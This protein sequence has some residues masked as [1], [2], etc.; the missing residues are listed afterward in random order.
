MLTKKTKKYKS[1]RIANIF[2]EAG[3][4]QRSKF[5]QNSIDAA[6]SA[7][8]KNNLGSTL[9]AIGSGAMGIV[10]ASLANAEIDTTT[11]DNAIDAVNSFQPN[12]GSLSALSSSYNNLNFADTSYD[13]KDYMVSTKQGL[14]N[15]GKAAMSGAVAGAQVGGPW[16]AI[17]RGAV[18]LLGSGAGW[19]AGKSKAKNEAIRLETEALMAN[20]GAENKAVTS[21][22][23]LLGDLANAERRNIVARGGKIFT[24]RDNLFDTGGLMHQHG[25]IFSNG[26]ITVDN[27]GTHEE[28]P[29][30]GVQIGV[31]N[32]GVPNLV[33]E[34]E[35]IWN[36]YV[37]SNRLEPSEEFKKK[38]K[39]KGNTFAEV[40]K[41][42]QKES[43]ERPNDPIS[44]RGLEYLMT[45]LMEEQEIVR[46]ISNKETSENMFDKGGKKSNKSKSDTLDTTSMIDSIYEHDYYVNQLG[47]RSVEE[48]KRLER[49]AGFENALGNIAGAVFPPPTLSDLFSMFRENKK[50][51]TGRKK[52]NKLAWG[53]YPFEDEDN[54]NTGYSRMSPD[55]VDAMNREAS[56]IEGRQTGMAPEVVDA[57][58]EQNRTGIYNGT[59]TNKPKVT[60]PASTSSTSFGNNWMRYTPV[61]GSALGALSDIAGITNKPDYTNVNFI[62]D[63]TDRIAPINYRPINARLSYTPFDTQFYAGKLGNQVAATKRAI[64]NTAPTASAAMSGLLT[65]DY[66]GQ[67]KLGELYRSAEEYNQAQKEKVL[68]FNR[69]TEALNSEGFLKADTINK[70]ADKLKLQSAIYQANLRNQIDATASAAKS[71]NLTNFFDNMGAVGKENY[72]MNMIEKNPALLYNW[73]GEYKNSS[74]CGGMLTKRKRRRK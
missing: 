65:A 21:R 19:L 61:L 25:G 53:G 7:F 11:A 49:E 62:K 39:V 24:M 10:D 44:K 30:E 36:N 28:N 35:L 18:G 32:Q 13:Y 3:E 27:G 59:S 48:G 26:I 60:T 15:M 5:T 73:L 40:A 8:S 68:G 56:F 23:Y 67:T 58:A 29:Y 45:K 12:T 4:L 52:S 63:A 70:E 20:A 33:E 1:K 46:S 22:D 72:I 50:Y 37:F 74:A 57:I 2:S 14:G 17:V 64:Q 34:G 71:A 41:E 31:D 51:K 69:E 43:A 16:G 38:Y 47:Y 42:M 66:N 54:Q 6:K 55:V 9:G